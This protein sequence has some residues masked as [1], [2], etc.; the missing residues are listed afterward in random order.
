MKFIKTKIKNL[1]IINPE[2]YI[3]RRGSFRRN[4]CKKEFQQEKINFN[5]KQTNISQNKFKY[6]LRGFHFQKGKYAEDKII[7]CIK[8]EIYNIVLDMRKNSLTYLKWKYFVL[9]DKNRISII[10]PKGCANA[11][12][13]LKDDTQIFYYHSQFY[14]KN[15]EEKVRYN[16]PFFNFKWPKK[17]KKISEVDK[18]IKDY[19]S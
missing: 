5:I 14:N 3:D 7:T 16:D 10:V 13:T 1:Y 11:Y 2:P 8:G 19:F 9:N 4:F 12:L 6:T 15:S 17:P 18:N